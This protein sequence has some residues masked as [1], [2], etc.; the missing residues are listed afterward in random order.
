MTGQQIIISAEQKNRGNWIKIYL[1]PAFARHPLAI[2]TNRNGSVIK[3]VDLE[4]GSNAI[5]ASNITDAAVSV[6][7]QTQFQTIVK[8][9]I[10]K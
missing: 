7:V 2:I 6:K 8:E 4:A 3:T 9:V 1:P 10:L 5:D